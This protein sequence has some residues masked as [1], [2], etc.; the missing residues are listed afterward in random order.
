MFICML[1]DTIHANYWRPAARCTDIWS[2]FNELFKN[3]NAFIPEIY[4]IIF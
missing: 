4:G 1:Q 2:A 3:H